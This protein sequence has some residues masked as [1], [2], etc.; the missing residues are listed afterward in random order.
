MTAV[1]DTRVPGYAT[2]KNMNSFLSFV[3]K[4]E[5]YT[6]CELEDSQAIFHIQSHF[7]LNL[8]KA[9]SLHFA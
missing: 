8:L 6:K 1:Y 9:C 2:T 3:V 5:H 4:V 7:P